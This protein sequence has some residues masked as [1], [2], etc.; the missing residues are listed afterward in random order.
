M[1]D[2][3]TNLLREVNNME[4]STNG[5]HVIVDAWGVDF[6]KL[7]NLETLEKTMRAGASRSGATVLSSQSKQFEPNGVTIL[8]LLSESH[9]S[10]HTYP[11]KGFAGIDCYTCGDTVNPILAVR[12]L[13]SYL[14]PEGVSLKVVER[15]RETG[16]RDE[17]SYDTLIDEYTRS[18]E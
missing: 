1:R 3:S 6:R 11:E 4:Y 5:R 12:T 16:V 8:L 13:L 15:G 7:D 18:E 10:I 14:Q 2:G 9:F 17:Y